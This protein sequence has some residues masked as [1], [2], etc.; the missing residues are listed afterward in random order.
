MPYERNADLPKTVRNHLPQGAQTMYR[1][2]YNSAW[3]QYKDPGKRRGSTTREATAHSVAWAAV[4]EAYVKK[5]DKWVK[6]P[7]K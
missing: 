6:K 4:K 5:A 3:K 2:T 7:K 1:K